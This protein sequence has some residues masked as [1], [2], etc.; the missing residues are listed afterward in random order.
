MALPDLLKLREIKYGERVGAQ[1]RSRHAATL[2]AR[3]F[4][5]EALDL[6]LLAG[7]EGGI[8]GFRTLASKQGRPLLL[9]ML[10]R[11]GRTVTAAEWAA[12]GEACVA[13][14]R[15]R[16]AYRSF[17]AAGDEAAVAK[18]REKIPDFEPYTPVGK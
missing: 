7:D 12:C 15:W 3:G 16:E 8:A 18:V 9:S 10:A 14:E 1:E 17:V 4:T 13:A 11:T 6:Y 5:V 2:A